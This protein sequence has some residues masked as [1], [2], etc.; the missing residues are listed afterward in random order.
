MFFGH[1]TGYTPESSELGACS[2]AMIPVVLLEFRAGGMFSGHD[3]GYTPESSEL[4][5]CSLAMTQ[6][7]PLRAQ[8]WGHVLRP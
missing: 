4:G 7:I 1:D 3:P 5:A 8:S 2:Q 6:V